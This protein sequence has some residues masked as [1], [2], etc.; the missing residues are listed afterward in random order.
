MADPSAAPSVFPSLFVG[1][2]TTLD[3]VWDP[4]N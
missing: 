1:G 2:L 4:K 3:T